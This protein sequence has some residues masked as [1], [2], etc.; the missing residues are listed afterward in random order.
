DP[1]N[2]LFEMCQPGPANFPILFNDFIG[3]SY[4]VSIVSPPSSGTASINAFDELVYTPNAGFTG[5]DT[6]TYQL[7][8]LCG[9]CGTAPILITVS[10]AVPIVTWS[11]LS[12]GLTLNFTDG[13]IYNI[14]SWLWDFGDGNT[15]T[16]Q[17]PTH[18]YA[19]FGVYTV[20]LTATNACGESVNCFNN[21]PVN[22]CEALEPMDDHFSYCLNGANQFNV[23]ANDPPFS[24][25]PLVY[26]TIPPVHGTV[27]WI[28]QSAGIFEYQPSTFTTIDSFEYTVET[29]NCQS[30]TAWVY[31]TCQQSGGGVKVNPKI[32]LSGFWN[33]NEGMMRGDLFEQD[34][35]PSSQPFTGEPWNY[36]GN[37]G[38]LI[39]GPPN[40]CK[41]DWVLVAIIDPFNQ[42]DIAE[43]KAGILWSDG[44]V[45]TVDGDAIQFDAPDGDYYVAILPRNHGAI[46]TL[47][48]ISLN[49]DQATVIDF[50]DPL[51]D[52][53]GGASDR[54]P[55]GPF[56]GVPGGDANGDGAINSVD[57]N[58]YWRPQNG[59][60]P[61]YDNQADFNG[62]GAVNSVDL[63]AIF[64][65]NNGWN[66]NVPFIWPN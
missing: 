16:L 25:Q 60:T 30:E 66:I 17:N 18:T 48:P 22:D 58:V 55:A 56:E 11:S 29:P 6:L 32:I 12:N 19:S 28:N 4:T 21:L 38:G 47:N 15:S 24:L 5:T 61:S 1:V 8:N 57:L 3:G 27:N 43:L 35:A 52:T 33:E 40:S 46:S 59:A 65:P 14:T 31:L 64:R 39:F 54:I 10:D 44:C 37:E 26:V 7:C 23:L 36:Q 34:L 2:D 13:S 41:V 51:T 45:R 50:T 42:D 9:Q 20:C 53:Y 62:D 63:N 49:S